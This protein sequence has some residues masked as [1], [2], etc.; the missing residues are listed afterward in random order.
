MNK[1]VSSVQTHKNC[2][3]KSPSLPVSITTKSETN[4]VQPVTSEMEMQDPYEIEEK[5]N[6]M[7][8]NSFELD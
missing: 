8:P 5:E 1:E 7:T 4:F 2:F 6:C 3:K